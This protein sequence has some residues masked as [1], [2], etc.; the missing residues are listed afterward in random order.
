MSA[1]DVPLCRGGIHFTESGE[2]LLPSS[3]VAHRI[4]R[5]ARMVRYLIEGGQLL[6]VR[7]GKLLFCSDSEVERYKRE[8]RHG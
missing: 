8:R 7:R 6:G 5:T 2:R 4:G 3:A 1:R